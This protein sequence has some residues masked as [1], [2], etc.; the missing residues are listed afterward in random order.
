MITVPLPVAS[1]RVIFIGG[2]NLFNPLHHAVEDS[3]VREGNPVKI[4]RE[5]RQ[6][7]YPEFL[8]PTLFALLRE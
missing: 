7:L 4:F 6:I 1:T 8:D 3:A 2:E 5:E